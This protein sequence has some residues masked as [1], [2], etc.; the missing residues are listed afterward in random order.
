MSQRLGDKREMPDVPKPNFLDALAEIWSQINFAA[1]HMAYVRVY[2]QSDALRTKT[3]VLRDQ[4]QLVRD[5]VQVD[6]VIC[7]TH[8]AAFFWHLEHV[9]EAL[10]TA[11]IRGQKEHPDLTYFWGYAERLD[12]IEQFTIRQEIKDYRNMGHQNLAIIGSK[13]NGEGRF[14]HHFL[15]TISGH[16]HKEDI[17]MNTRLQQYFEFATNVWLEFAPGDFKEKFP[18]DFRFPVTVPYLF[19]GELPKELKGVPQL[20]VC[21][22]SYDRQNADAEVVKDAGQLPNRALGRLPKNRTALS[23]I[24]TAH[25]LLRAVLVTLVALKISKLLKTGGGSPV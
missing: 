4:D 3:D 12:E 21:V 6:I 18:R 20:E 8:L 23:K 7:R 14:L 10:R 1:Y 24:C 19:A 2:S 11:V 17:E 25:A 5:H 22:Q 13:W 16:Q 9:F 15:P